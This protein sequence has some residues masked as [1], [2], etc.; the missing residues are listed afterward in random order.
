MAAGSRADRE[1]GAAVEGE[2]FAV[3]DAGVIVST[4]LPTPDSP[5]VEA[6]WASMQSDGVQAYSPGL[7]RYELASVLRRYVFDRL[8][9]EASAD[10][11][12]KN[13]LDL[14]I[15]TIDETPDFH[16][17]ALRWA[18]RLSHRAAYDGFYVAAAERLGAVLW[19]CDGRLA[20]RAQQ[21]GAPWVKEVAR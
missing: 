21:I 19:T 7:W 9:T 8:V 12:L 10:A 16:V 4:V 17:A 11:A 15:L 6:L 14:G 13:A 20:R 18:S 3:V 1:P 2:D 5:R